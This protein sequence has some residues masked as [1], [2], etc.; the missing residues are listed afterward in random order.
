MSNSSASIHMVMTD[1][2]GRQMTNLDR[3]KLNSTSFRNRGGM[4]YVIN[5]MLLIALVG[6]CIKMFFGNNTS[7]DG[8]Y[9][10]ASSTIY[11]YGVVAF[12][13]LTVMF[14]TFAVHDRVGR[15]ENKGGLWGILSFLKGFLTSS[16]PSIFTI[17][18]LSWIISLNISH[19]TQINKGVAATEYFQLSKGS[20]FLIII[21]ILCLFQ[22]LKLFINNLNPIGDKKDAAANM[23]RITFATYFIIAINLIV[24]GMMTIILTFFST[25]G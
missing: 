12:A 21:Q 10:H 8:T 1:K 17:I 14:I 2:E 18:T 3:L 20:S 19:F 24:A 5:S 4:E 16:A 7:I 13:V 11:G 22:Y 6:M 23:A 15:M 9:G 25:D